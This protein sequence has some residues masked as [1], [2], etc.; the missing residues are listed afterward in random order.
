MVWVHDM[1]SLPSPGNARLTRWDRFGLVLFALLVV[2]FGVM[3]EI[4]SAFQRQRKTDFGVYARAAWAVRS[5]WDIYEVFDDRGWHYCYPPPF[6]VVMVPLA[7]PPTIL[8]DRAGYLPFSVSVG[9]WYLLG[10]AFVGYATHAF[11][12]AV[13]PDAVRGSRRWWYARTV[14]IL[15]CAGG[16]GFTL[17]RGQVNT[18]VVAL[19]AGMFAAAIR[20]RAVAAGAWLAGAI[21]L[22]VIPG[23]LLLFPVVRR[24]WRA[25]IG[26][27]AMGAFLFGVLPVAVWGVDG[28]VR[29]NLR[30]VETVLKP[31]TTGGGDQT[32][33][34]ELTDTTATDSQTFQAVIHAIRHPDPATR[35]AKADRETRLA[36]WGIGGLLTLITAVVGWRRLGPEP[37]D[38]LVFLGCLCVLMLLLTPVSHMHY[39]AM[40]M[41]IVCGLWLRSMAKRPGAIGADPVTLG[42]LVLWGFATAIPLFPWG[43]TSFLRE[44]GAGVFATVGL[45]G[46]ALLTIATRIPRKGEAP[47]FLALRR[48]LGPRARIG[49]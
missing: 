32:R 46:F 40:A 45:W 41:P 44:A 20:G 36:H 42:V 31:G 27:V 8:A 25:G 43:I 14:P 11:A 21:A 35:P 26:L 7:D 34:K 6:A 19:V 13:L 2:V 23:I 38:Q 28:A 37:G 47:R 5:G 12:S 39:Y 15:V 17:G 49:S 24:D 3:V 22:K 16:I 29:N 10:F 4:R 18:L 33:A 48:I 9:I 30:I 1:T